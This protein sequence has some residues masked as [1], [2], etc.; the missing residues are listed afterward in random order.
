[1]TTGI[2]KRWII[3]LIACLF[4]STQAT[5]LCHAG[6]LL[7]SDRTRNSVYRYS[8]SGT[9]LGTLLTDNVNLNQPSGIQLSPESRSAIRL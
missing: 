6:E 7:V 1:M 3:V 2:M 4:S 5:V 8:E 9:F